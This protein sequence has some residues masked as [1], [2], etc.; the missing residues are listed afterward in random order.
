MEGRTRR[1]GLLRAALALMVPALLVWSSPAR[2][3]SKPMRFAHLSV[4]EGLSQT[5]V[6]TM[7][8]DSYGFVWL[9]TEDGLNRFDGQTVKVYKHDLQDAA[10]LPHDLVWSIAEDPSGDLWI[11]TEGG[12]LARWGRETDRFERFQ[13]DPKDESSLSSDRVRIVFVDSKG[14][15]WVGTKDAGLNRFDPRSGSFT[16]YRHVADDPASL[17]HDGVYALLEDASGVL[18]VGTE[19]GLNRLD[20]ESESFERFR[21]DPEDPRSL[22][23]DRVRALAEDDQGTLWVGTLDAGLNER[24]QGSR[25]FLRHRHDPRRPGS[26]ADDCVHAVHRD[27]AGRLWVGTRSG[28][29]LLQ[30]SG[31]F[32]HYRHDPLNLSSL[33]DDEVMSLLEDR[34]GVL[35]AGTRAGGASRWNPA[36]WAFGHVAS[37]P[38]DEDGLSH[39]YV[40]SFTDDALGRLWVGTMGGGI[41]VFDRGS[42]EVRHFR[43]DPERPGSLSDDRVMALARGRSG[44]IWVGTMEGGLNRFD[45]ET[46]RFRV[47]RADPGRAGTLSTDA[48][49]SL[50][51]D[52]EGVLWVGTYR[53]GL[54]RYDRE[55][56]SFTVYRHDPSNPETL[57]SDVVT[58]VQEGPAGTVWV[59]TE[60]GGLN[61]LDRR[62]GTFQ[63]F[64]HDRKRATS[65]SDDTIYSVYVDLAGTVWVGTRGGLSR[66]ESSSPATGEASFRTYTERDGLPNK[67]IYGIQPDGMGRLWLSTN[68][69][70][71]RFDP[72]TETFRDYSK[73]HGLQSNEFT[74]GAH[75][76]TTRGELVFGGPQGF[77]AFFAETIPTNEH[78]PPVVLTAFLKSNRPAHGETAPFALDGVTLGYKDDMVTFE[79]AALDYA[80]PERNRYV[81]KLEGFDPEWIDLGSVHRVTYTDLAHGDYVLRVKAAN[82]DGVWN[83][84]G[85]TLPVRVLPPPWRTW[86]AYLAYALA[87]AGL[88]ARVVYVQRKK[89]TREAEYRRRL[90]LEVEARTEELGRQNE[91]LETL[92]SQLVETSFTDSLTGLRNR[93]FLF[94]EVNKEMNLVHRNHRELSRGLRDSADELIFMMVDLDW[95]KPI[96]DTCGHAAGDRVLLQVKQLLEKACRDSDTLIRW[97]GDE[98]LV[99]GRVNDL[100]GVEAAAERIRSLIEGASFDLGDGQVAHITCSIGFTCYPAGSAEMLGLSLEQVVSL[101][102]KALYSAKKAGR[103][104]WVGL[105]GTSSTSIESVLE[106]LQTDADAAP[107]EGVFEIR[108]STSEQLADMAM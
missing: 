99:V 10:S 20:T 49:M 105:L 18:W 32:A 60:G 50:L 72:R 73:T 76:R 108:R 23:G 61:R 86:W 63:S 107:Q 75:F 92:N 3:E 71:A 102:D 106:T 40:T 77:N 79:F 12:G 85:L 84:E 9:G 93:R 64:H 95:F 51:A 43:H 45:P 27:G 33:A 96:N 41:D 104:A 46:G 22:S 54:N 26:L 42:G 44:T 17:S 30:P 55:S 87:L 82:N 38:G 48:V 28:L 14:V 57:S 16:R 91:R 74:F 1:G 98:F 100:E 29:D 81:Y 67:V 25:G 36:T 39:D 65:L 90:E 2:A 4:D 6:L 68:L 47:Y 5:S 69:G 11:G 66:L 78:V 58:C 101:A 80:D 15:V 97:G 7:L 8:Q 94:E 34:G 83:E 52:R 13:H 70:L 89:A 53:G 62:A 59:G 56:D 19:G 88:V 37:S 24:P 103:N 21:H 35:W 31:D